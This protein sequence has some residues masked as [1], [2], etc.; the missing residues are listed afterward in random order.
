MPADAPQDGERVRLASSYDYALPEELIA[1]EPAARRDAARLLVVAS[2]GAFHDR[3][4]T[5]F[6]ALLHPGDVLVINETQVIPA[7]LRGTRPGGGA[8]EVLLLRPRD[9]DDFSY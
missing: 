6:P 1:R 9:R 4:F 5:D 3:V 7:R 2:D 8:M